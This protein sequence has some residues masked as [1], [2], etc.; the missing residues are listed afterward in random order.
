MA[1]LPQFKIM[2]EDPRITE[3]RRL[4]HEVTRD[5]RQRAKHL[6]DN[7]SCK[8]GHKRTEHSVAYSIN[9]TGGICAKCKCKNF[10]KYTF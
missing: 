5:E 10:L 1:N 3:A 7:E 8:C 4:L 9:Y 2:Q 6:S